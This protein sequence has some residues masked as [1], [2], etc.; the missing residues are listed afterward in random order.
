MEGHAKIQGELQSLITAVPA[1]E[2]ESNNLNITNT[3]EELDKRQA[4][5]EGKLQALE[6]AMHASG[7][8]NIKEEEERG[9]FDDVLSVFKEGWDKVQETL[10][11]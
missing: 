11:N 8:L 10:T 3:L 2:L 1:R 5:I 9:P 7:V 4:K 6:L